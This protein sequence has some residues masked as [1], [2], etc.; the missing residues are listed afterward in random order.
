MHNFRV[1]VSLTARKKL[2]IGVIMLIVD[3]NLLEANVAQEGNMI[4]IISLMV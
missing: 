2:L 1:I 4:V 3:R